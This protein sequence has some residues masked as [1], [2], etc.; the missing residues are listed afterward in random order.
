MKLDPAVKPGIKLPVAM[1]DRAEAEPVGNMG[2]RTPVPEPTEWVSSMVA[3]HKKNS[4]DKDMHGLQRS[5]QG[6][7]VS[8][9]LHAYGS[10]RISNAQF[11][12]LLCYRGETFFLD[13]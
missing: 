8:T 1:Q 12:C 4:G 10:T 9:L 6:A 3:T 11:L 5:E 2:V 7:P 13:C